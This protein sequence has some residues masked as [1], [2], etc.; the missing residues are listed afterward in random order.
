MKKLTA[1]KFAV[2]QD[3]NDAE[4]RF[5]IPMNLE[6]IKYFA[7]IHNVE[8]D[9]HSWGYTRID[10]TVEEI[11]IPFTRIASKNR[12]RY[13][14][15]SLIRRYTYT[16]DSG[17]FSSS[18]SRYMLLA[19]KTLVQIST[20]L[21]EVLINKFD[22]KYKED[23]N[24]KTIIL[25]ST[26][27]DE[28]LTE[29][30]VDEGRL[31]K[32]ND[33][34]AIYGTRSIMRYHATY[35]SKIRNQF[36]KFM[37]KT[38]GAWNFGFEVEKVD[39]LWCDEGNALK[40]SHDTGWKKEEDGSLGSHGFE[41]ISPVLPLYNQSVIN[42]CVT[43]VRY[44]INA[45]YNDRC[46][47]H[48][49]LSRQGLSSNAILKGLKGS[50]PLFYMMYEKRMTNHFCEAKNFATYL[51]SPKKYSAFYLKSND[52]LEV[53][54]FPA[55]KSDSVLQNRIDLLRTLLNKFGDSSSK[56]IVELA[57][58]SSPLHTL[59]SSRFLGMSTD[60]MVEKIRLF[61]RLSEQW[62]CGKITLGAKKKVNK[63]MLQEVFVIPVNTPPVTPVPTEDTH[64][65]S[66][67]SSPVE[68]S[69]D[70]ISVETAQRIHAISTS[71]ISIFGQPVL[72]DD[73]TI[74]GN[75]TSDLPYRPND[76]LSQHA[77]SEGYFNLS[78]ISSSN[79]FARVMTEYEDY[80]YSQM[81]Q[82]LMG[83]LSDGCGE[84]LYLNN[85]RF[86]VELSRTSTQS[87]GSVI[88]R[89]VRAFLGCLSANRFI[90]DGGPY[91]TKGTFISSDGCHY[92]N[93]LNKSDRFV[94]HFGLRGQGL[95]VRITYKDGIITIDN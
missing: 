66:V 24:G 26:M 54:L 78:I 47:G 55:V 89:Y 35:P 50:V 38:A 36:V 77:P 32:K 69:A 41:L 90:R 4:N 53:R 29:S 3:S 88:R 56:V 18:S 64:E 86:P 37:D 16:M 31:V 81:V 71:D 21:F 22:C 44:L 15:E 73:I 7:K 72:V 93:T 52:I 95:Q 92:Y 34:S 87:N 51:R 84:R 28:D 17:Y 76:S 1:R 43:Q 40:L 60:K 57:T 39:S 65:E 75:N 85:N 14:T 20:S 33:T 11:S 12:E 27:V 94:G 46:G 19:D 67:E 63:L 80:S 62:G 9:S 59:I 70:D 10:N 49:N 58:P 74:H 61:A 2:L 42:Q 83:Q 5:I 8:H 68:Q 48:I 23:T 6:A 82:E 45:D 91:E 79:M 13:N 25:D 30:M